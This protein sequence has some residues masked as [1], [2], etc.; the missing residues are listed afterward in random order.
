MKY[1]AEWYTPLNLEKKVDQ[2]EVRREYTR[3]RD[4][5]QKRLKRL[6]NAAIRDNV[7]WTKTEIY[8][9]YKKGVPKLSTISKKHLPY[10]T[11]KLARWVENEQ[12][13]IGYLRKRAKSA[14]KKLHERG[15]DFINESNY[16]SFIEF[17]EEYRRQKLDHVYGSPEVVELFW[18]LQEKT[19]KPESV[20]KDFS[21]WI[22]NQQ[23]LSELPIMKHGALKTYKMTLSKAGR[24]KHAK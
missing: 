6:E 4:I 11:A 16:M 13:K 15:Y 9:Q 20:Y 1:P 22:E 18:A 17:M 2:S 23:A 19:I 12:S 14:I 8:K 21:S 3:L 24:W 5:A 10:E 7:D